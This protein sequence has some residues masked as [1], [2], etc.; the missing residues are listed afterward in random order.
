L[1]NEN[2]NKKKGILLELGVTIASTK[3]C[4]LKAGNILKIT[5]K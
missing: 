1:A 4:Q 3:F 2:G 5:G